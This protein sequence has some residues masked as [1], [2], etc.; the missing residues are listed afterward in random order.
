M[1]FRLKR[2]YNNKKIHYYEIPFLISIIIP[3]ITYLNNKLNISLATN[4][5]K[6]IKNTSVIVDASL[7]AWILVLESIIYFILLIC[8]CITIFVVCKDKLKGLL[9]FVFLMGG[10]CSK[11]ILGFSPTVYA[12]GN[13]TGIY[14]LFCVIISI[15]ILIQQLLPF[16]SKKYK[17]FL[18][19]S[20]VL[21]A[22]SMLTI[23]FKNMGMF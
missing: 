20:L 7:A 2:F 23:Y 1:I 9:A 16:M 18:N 3:I 6:I 22:L 19:V 13:R 10:F 5:L 4:F 15:L 8:I 12:S 14:L 17:L 21:C 11:V